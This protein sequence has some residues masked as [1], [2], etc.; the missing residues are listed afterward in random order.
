M[1]CS[2]TITEENIS[3]IFEVSNTLGQGLDLFKAFLNLLPINMSTQWKQNLDDSP[4]FH[5]TETFDKDGEPIL[6]G[7]VLKG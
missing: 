2:R 3:P 4:E 1:L 5:I 6:S 7:M